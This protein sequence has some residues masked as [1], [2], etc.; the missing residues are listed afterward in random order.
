MKKKKKTFREK[1]AGGLLQI[2]E[3]HDLFM[4]TDRHNNQTEMG[5][6]SGELTLET[7]F[8]KLVCVAQDFGV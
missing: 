3:F 2:G 6:Q 5:R 1:E 4:F 7:T 8:L